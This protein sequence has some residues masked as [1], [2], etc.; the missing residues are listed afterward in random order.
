MDDRAMS[1]KKNLPSFDDRNA[2]VAE[3]NRIE[4]LDFLR[5]FALM[6]ILIVN[7]QAMAM[8]GSAY[9]NPTAYGDYTGLNR[10]VFLLTFFFFE[11]KMMSIF[12]MLFG[13]GIILMTDRLAK[14]SNPSC[15]IHFRRMF[16]LL[17]FGLAHAHL[18]WYGDILYT[19]AL[20]GVL[21]Y[22]LR[23][24]APK[25]LL[26]MGTVAILVPFG[27]AMMLDAGMNLS[28]EFFAEMEQNWKPDQM[29]IDAELAAYR[30][31]WLEQMP[32]RS[33][34][35]LSFELFLFPMM[36]FWRASGL[37]LL[38]MAFYKTKMLTGEW[39]M[40]RYQIGAILGLGI[41]WALAA[42]SLYWCESNDW[43]LKSSMFEGSQFNVL[44]SVVAAIGYICVGC[45]LCK[46]NWLPAV[47]HAFGSAGR[48]AL[49][50]YL[51]Q[52][53][54]VTLVFYGHGLGYFGYMSRLEQF[55][56]V[57]TIWGLQ[58][59]ISPIWLSKFRF[60]PAEWL[61]RSLVY[62][63]VQPLLR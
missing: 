3:V 13:A 59:V 8:I 22:F 4:T 19:Y 11:S 49:T 27:V 17:L 30:G 10:I 42:V 50:N 51:M 12:S 7:I 25:Y 45:M 15:W 40:R 16:W 14:K 23:R 6:G 62:W 39:S 5:G 41:G 18:I 53:V 47:R 55:G 38:G 46:I 24:L 32:T 44:G 56:V 9:S 1:S 20:C 63:K 36:F 54:L 21:V 28:D 29:A 48:L 57:L 52:S 2:P 33:S 58:L 26:T 61:W 60:G 31:S 43:A 34:T 35:A 37:M